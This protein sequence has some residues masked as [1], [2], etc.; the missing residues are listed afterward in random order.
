V[1]DVEVGVQLNVKTEVV[2]VSPPK[3]KE[4]I[5]QV[6]KVQEVPPPEKVEENF[7]DWD[8]SRLE[9]DLM[10]KNKVVEKIS[11]NERLRKINVK[12]GKFAYKHLMS[13][14]SSDQLMKPLSKNKSM[15]IKTIAVRK[16]ETDS[17]GFQH[18]FQNYI[19]SGI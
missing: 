17:S 9:D 15:D 10:S 1:K 14:A 3:I 13:A 5:E 8:V 12:Y 19:H 11:R 6:K 18:K 4:K 7:Q 2:T 16:K